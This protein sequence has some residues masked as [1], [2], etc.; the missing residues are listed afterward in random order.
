M[1]TPKKRKIKLT[2]LQHKHISN[3][4]NNRTVAEQNYNVMKNT[5]QNVI[6]LVLDAHE[7]SQEDVSSVDMIEGQS[8]E[9]TLSE[10]KK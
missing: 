4:V 8:I 3:A 6:A 1:A 10:N 7:V 5:E 9:L 2:D